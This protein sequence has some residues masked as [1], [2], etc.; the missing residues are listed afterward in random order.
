M[1]DAEY[2]L[3]EAHAMKDAILQALGE[4]RRGAT[5]DAI[6]TLERVALPKFFDSY[7]AADEYQRSLFPSIEAK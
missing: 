1:A 5:V 3:D 2:W 7:H 6:T 4:L